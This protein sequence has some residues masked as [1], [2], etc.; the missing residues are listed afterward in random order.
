MNELKTMGWVL[1]SLLCLSVL[2]SDGCYE[3]SP[4]AGGTNDATLFTWK[5]NKFTGKV[6]WCET[7][8]RHGPV[9]CW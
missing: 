2:F 7:D 1:G 8:L 6:S 3:L 9:R 5:V 4:V